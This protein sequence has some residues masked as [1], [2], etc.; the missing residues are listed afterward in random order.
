M[1][2][3][4]GFVIWMTGLP[5]SGKTTIA[6]WLYDEFRKRGLPV[7]VLDGDVVR[8]EFGGDLGYSKS[9]RD[10]NIARVAYVADLLSRHGVVVI[11]SLVSPYREA[12]EQARKRIKRFFEVYVNCSIEV[13]VQRDVKG[14]YRR[15]IG[16][17]IPNF[18]GISDTYEPPEQPDMEVKTDHCTVA[19]AGSEIL[20]ALRSQGFLPD[21][22]D[23]QTGAEA[24]DVENETAY[25]ANRVR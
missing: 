5:S 18:T 19:E 12:R 16:G 1:R 3:N 25:I 6:N 13:C 17:E 20:K 2:E 8:R 14:L 4:N 11:V 7:E 15:A 22:G 23:T 9:D 24:G 21:P 10:R